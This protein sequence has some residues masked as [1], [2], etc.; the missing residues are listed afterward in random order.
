MSMSD[1]RFGCG[2]HDHCYNV[3]GDAG[4]RPAIFF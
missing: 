4:Q 1:C 3:S 2:E